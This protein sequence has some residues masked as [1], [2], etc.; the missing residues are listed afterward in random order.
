MICHTKQISVPKNEFIIN[1]WSNL[2]LGIFFYLNNAQVNLKA[3]LVN[4][5]CF[6][7]FLVSV[8]PFGKKLFLVQMVIHALIIDCDMQMS[9]SFFFII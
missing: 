7:F 6:F 9:G 5:L 4:F 3:D 8:F 2:M 1:G